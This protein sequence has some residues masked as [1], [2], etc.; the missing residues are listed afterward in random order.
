MSLLLV[1]CRSQLRCSPPHFTMTRRPDRERESWSH[2]VMWAK[3]IDGGWDWLFH[4][5]LEA[6][7]QMTYRSWLTW[8]VS[9]RC[10]W[11]YSRRSPTVTAGIEFISDRL[12]WH[13]PRS[14]A[15]DWKSMSDLLLSTKKNQ[16]CSGAIGKKGKAFKRVWHSTFPLLWMLPAGPLRS[17]PW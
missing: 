11:C 10:W 8:S 12:K 7:V 1:F 3:S 13:V 16:T 9:V 5:F 6:V 2:E 4:I 15:A 14:I 17:N